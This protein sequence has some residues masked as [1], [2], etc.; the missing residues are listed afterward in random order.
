MTFTPSAIYERNRHL[1]GPP[2][3]AGQRLV[4][5][6][7]AVLKEPLTQPAVECGYDMPGLEGRANHVHKGAGERGTGW[8][9]VGSQ[10]RGQER[11]GSGDERGRSSAGQ[12]DG[13]P[14][15]RRDIRGRNMCI[16]G[17]LARGP[18]DEKSDLDTVAT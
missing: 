15:P 14:A 13:D 10:R 9:H 16:F 1:D 5:P 6:V 11:T 7:D 17:S 3:L 4:P 12:A 18:A 2:R 8:Y